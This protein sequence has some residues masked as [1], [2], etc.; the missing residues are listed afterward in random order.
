MPISSLTFCQ[1]NEKHISTP[2][3]LRMSSDMFDER[4][5]SVALRTGTLP[6][7]SISQ[8]ANR[9]EKYRDSSSVIFTSSMIFA[10]HNSRSNAPIIHSLGIYQCNFLYVCFYIIF[11]SLIVILISKIVCTRLMRFSTQHL[12]AVHANTAIFYDILLTN[13]FTHKLC[14]AEI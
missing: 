6:V 13:F 12:S 9:S 2:T 11:F 3:F 4:N 8:H 5:I 1:H 14:K 7:F 10:L